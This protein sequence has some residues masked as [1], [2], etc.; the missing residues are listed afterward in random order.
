VCLVR[1][2]GRG[3]SIPVLRVFVSETDKGW[4]QPTT[5]YSLRF[6]MKNHP[7]KTEQ[8]EPSHFNGASSI[9]FHLPP[10]GTPSEDGRTS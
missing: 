3:E 6:R 5:E 10:V 8:T 4:V 9:F 7:P 2:A 1:E